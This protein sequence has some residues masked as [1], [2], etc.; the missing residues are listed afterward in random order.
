MVPAASNADQGLCP[1][2][3]PEGIIPSG[4]LG[5]YRVLGGMLMRWVRGEGLKSYIK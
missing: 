4:L 2:T 1:W 3:P 5:C